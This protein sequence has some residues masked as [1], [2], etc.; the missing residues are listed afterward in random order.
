MITPPLTRR[1]FLRAA[2]GAVLPARSGRAWAAGASVRVEDWAPTPLGT[3]GVPPGWRKY[4]TPGGRPAYDFTVVEDAGRRALHM[5]SAGEHSTIAKEVQADLAA[6]PILAWQWRVLGLPQG[7]DLRNR[8]TSDATGHLF[9]VWPRFP[10]FARS[11]LIG[12]VWDPALPTGT[13]IPSRKTGAVTFIVARRGETGLGQWLDERRNVADD[14]RTV[15]GEA[16]PPLPALALS[17]DTNDT[18]ASAECLVGR[19]ELRPG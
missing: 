19:I 7:A 1:A 18:R 13:V 6:T 5:K 10:A 16:P 15:F 8:A 2:A 9:A 3:R 4:E 17:I 12:Y 11:R 14:Y